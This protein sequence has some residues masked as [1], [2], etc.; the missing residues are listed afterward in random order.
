MDY[1]VWFFR[2][3]EWTWRVAHCGI[4]E[5]VYR[6]PKRPGFI[7]EKFPASLPNPGSKT[8][9]FG[10]FF[11]IRKINQI[12]KSTKNQPKINQNI[13]CNTRPASPRRAAPRL[14]P[15]HYQYFVYGY[16]FR[17][18]SKHCLS[19]LTAASPMLNFH[20]K[21]TKWHEIRVPKNQP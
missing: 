4:R 9:I 14:L 12:E 16:T 13:F 5:Y 6:P 21:S 3:N 15:H 10:W 11:K 8:S 19:R 20:E 7:F 17:Q 18:N 2:A 1:S